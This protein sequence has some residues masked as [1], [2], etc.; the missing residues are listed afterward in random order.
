[1][2]TLDAMHAQR[3]R[4]ARLRI[5]SIFTKLK[6][7]GRAEA[8]IKQRGAGLGRTCDLSREELVRPRT[9]GNG[10]TGVEEA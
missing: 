6:V 4:G 7:A 9:P 5:P 2:V 3:L 10:V 8:I 1:M